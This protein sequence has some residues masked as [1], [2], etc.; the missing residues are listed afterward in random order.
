MPHLVQ[1]PHLVAPC[2]L[3]TIIL[4]AL[5]G[6]LA[7][8]Q[9]ARRG[10]CVPLLLAVALAVGGLV[11]RAAAASPAYEL[12]LHGLAGV[13]GAFALARSVL[14]SAALRLAAAAAGHVRFQA[15][16]LLV[17]GSALLGGQLYQVEPGDNDDLTR[18]M[19]DAAPV[20][21]TERAT[22][23][24]TDAGRPI[25]LCV[26]H[27]EFGRVPDESSDAT[28][29]E[30]R[31]LGRRVIQTA[32]ASLDCNCHGWVFAGGRH[33][34]RGAQVERIL[35]DNGYEAVSRPQPG[36][37]AIWRSHRGDLLHSGLVRSASEDGLVLIESKWGQAGRFIHTPEHHAYLGSN[38]TFY[39]SPRGS[40]LLRGL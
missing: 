10:W 7:L 30:E 31:Q 23:A 6:A 32:P 27:K 16:L 12:V 24:R 13:L 20:A 11:A 25:S 33:W 38:C 15:A 35:E 26:A 40:H 34:V 8:W 19:S 22:P 39:H 29:I 9:P 28:L 5:A 14:L 17:G 4:L 37:V 21:L 2:A 3:A 1:H 36:D 18:K